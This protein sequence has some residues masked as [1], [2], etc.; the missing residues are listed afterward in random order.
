MLVVSRSTVKTH[1]RNR[2]GKL[3]VNS[4]TQALARARNLQ[5]L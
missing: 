4:R 3:H 2:Y 1:L 5:L